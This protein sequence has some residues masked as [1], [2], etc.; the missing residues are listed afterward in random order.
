MSDRPQALTPQHCDTRLTKRANAAHAA[1][2][3]ALCAQPFG[4]ALRVAAAG[5]RQPLFGFGLLCGPGL[6]IACDGDLSVLLEALRHLL[7]AEDA[8]LAHDELVLLVD[9]H[10]AAATLALMQTRKRELL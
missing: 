1:A 10:L 5:Y 2:C 9:E 6:P 7:L 4:L 3:C 8:I